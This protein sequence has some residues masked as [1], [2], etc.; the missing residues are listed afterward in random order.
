MA[1]DPNSLI[2][3]L[4]IPSEFQNYFSLPAEANITEVLDVLCTLNYTQF[5]DEL[6]ENF[7]V[8]ALTKKVH[9][10]LLLGLLSENFMGYAQTKKVHTWLLLGLLF[11]NFMGYALTKKVHT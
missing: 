3:N 10:W 2:S 5:V 11:E 1:L 9:T 7:M 4:C 8:D 6:N